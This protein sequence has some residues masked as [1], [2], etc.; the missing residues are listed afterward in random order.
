M[1]TLLVTYDLIA[2]GRNYDPLWSFLESHSYWAKPVR[3]VYLIKTTQGAESFRNSVQTHIDSNDKVFV[4][5]VTSDEAAWVN[6][7]DTVSKW[8]KSNL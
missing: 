8:I 1:N 4:V 6:L 7:G 5:N 3:S 2:P